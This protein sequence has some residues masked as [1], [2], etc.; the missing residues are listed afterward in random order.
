MA[1]GSIVDPV[2]SLI[3]DT[4]TVLYSVVNGEQL[5]QEVTIGW[6]TDLT[7]FNVH[8]NIVEGLNDG[9][10]SHPQQAKPG[11]FRMLLT[12]ANGYLLGVSDGDNKFK[13]VIPFNLA[14]TAAPKPQPAAPIFFFFDLE[15]GEPG[16]GDGDPIGDFAPPAKQVWKPVRGLIEV[17]YSPTEDA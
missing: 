2:T 10:G 4:G 12:E 3:G 16:T 1:R 6:L 14:E 11:G 13:F 9:V 17:L 8:M 15:I 5:Q 7:G